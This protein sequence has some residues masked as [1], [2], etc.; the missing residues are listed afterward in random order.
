VLNGQ[1]RDGDRSKFKLVLHGKLLSKE[2]PTITMKVV[3]SEFL[4]VMTSRSTE[5]VAGILRIDCYTWY[6]LP[7]FILK[8]V[9]L[10]L[11]VSRCKFVVSY[12][13]PYDINT[14]R[15]LSIPGKLSEADNETRDIDINLDLTILSNVIN[16]I[17]IPLLQKVVIGMFHRVST[18][19]T[20]LFSEKSSEDSSQ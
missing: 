12:H 18:G 1:F 3:D 13:F 17:I 7:T 14:D 15:L 8:N 10:D 2:F 4:H 19:L 20:T 6:G 9:I 16:D 5:K 11:L